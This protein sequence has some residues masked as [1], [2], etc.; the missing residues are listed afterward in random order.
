MNRWIKCLA[1]SDLLGV[2]YYGREQ[3]SLQ[4]V[5]KMFKHCGSV[6]DDSP[7]YILAAGIIHHGGFLMSAS[8]VTRG[9]LP[10]IKSG[11]QHKSVR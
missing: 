2:G 8:A 1:D 7:V 9:W 6:V 4:L 5:K 3:V 11:M 10:G